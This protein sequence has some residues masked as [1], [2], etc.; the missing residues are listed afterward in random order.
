MPGMP[1]CPGKTVNNVL[2][3]L[4]RML[5]IAATWGEIVE[6]PVR[7]RLLKTQAKEMSFYRLAGD[8]ERHERVQLCLD[9]NL[10]PTDD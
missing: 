1:W 7:I 5:V 2:S 6:P 9:D 10:V 8:V 3:V 4:N